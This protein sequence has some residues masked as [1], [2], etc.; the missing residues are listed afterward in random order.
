MLLTNNKITLRAVEPADLDLLYKWENN[1]E[2]WMAGNTR[3]PFSKFVLKQ[4]ILLQIEKDIYDS[5]QLRLMIV[6]NA[7][8]NTVGTV[9]LYDFDL[10]NSRIALGLYVDYSFQ[11]QGFATEALHLAEEYVFKY[12][13]LQ[14]L[15]CHISVKNTASRS[16]FEREG[17]E[18]NGILKEWIKTPDGFENIIVF[19]RF[20]STLDLGV[21]G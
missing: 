13:K 15:Y 21:V 1:S 20:A 5:K 9:D 3:Q 12:L 4:Y 18:Q 10:H 7:G 2:L 17:Y 16:I 8:G 14:Q 6:E 19:Q 11:G